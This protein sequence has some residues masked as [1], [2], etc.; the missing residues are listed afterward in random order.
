KGSHSFVDGRN[1]PMKKLVSIARNVRVGLLCGGAAL[2]LAG[3]GGGTADGY[4]KTP[5]LAAVSY[6]SATGSSTLVVADSASAEATTA[7]TVADTTAPQAAP[8]F[9]LGGYGPA[10]PAS[11]PDAAATQGAGPAT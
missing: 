4:G 8:N 5:Q 7:P 11:Q 1:V 6:S 2:L 10:A 3:C 9:E